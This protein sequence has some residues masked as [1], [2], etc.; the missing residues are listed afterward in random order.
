MYFLKA[1]IFLLALSPF[2]QGCSQ[3]MEG[4]HSTQ[5]KREIIELLRKL[6]D[7]LYED[8]CRWDPKYICE[9]PRPIIDPTI[10]DDDAQYPQVPS[11]GHSPA[12]GISVVEDCELW[13][14]GSCGAKA[15]KG[16]NQKQSDDMIH[17]NSRSLFVQLPLHLLLHNSHPYL[18]SCI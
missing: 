13:D 9:P 14:D 12:F 7:M 2:T 3:M 4:K 10:M 11:G 18:S 6:A 15:A 16:K 8:R 17:Q 1:S 5:N